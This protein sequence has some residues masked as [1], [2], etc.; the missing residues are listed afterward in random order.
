MII[1]SDTPDTLMDCYGEKNN[2]NNQ[3]V[4]KNLNNLKR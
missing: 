2:Q 3:M 1:V 4:E